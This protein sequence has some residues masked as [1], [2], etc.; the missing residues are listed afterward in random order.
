MKKEIKVYLRAS[1]PNC[2]YY[3]QLTKQL[4]DV[5]HPTSVQP[6][7]LGESIEVSN[8]EIRVDDF[9]LYVTRIIG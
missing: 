8:D 1:R 9:G 5:T 4:T 2:W 7:S 6:I 3:K